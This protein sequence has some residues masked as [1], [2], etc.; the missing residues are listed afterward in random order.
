M[1]ED[2]PA[3]IKPPDAPNASGHRSASR[4]KRIPVTPWRDEIRQ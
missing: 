4:T 3:P 2:A 1:V